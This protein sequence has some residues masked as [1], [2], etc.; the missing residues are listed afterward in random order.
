M[1]LS[2]PFIHDEKYTNLLKNETANI[3]S[4]YFPVTINP[5]LDARVQTKPIELETLCRQLGK[6]TGIKKYVLINT[7]FIHPQK[8]SDIGYLTLFLDQLEILRKTCGLSGIVFS[9]A[10]LLNA[11]S[12]T[13]HAVVSE[14]EAVPGINCMIDSVPRALAMLQLIDDSGFKRPEKLI[15][16]R[17]LNRNFKVLEQFKKQ[18][19]LIRLELLANEGCLLHCPFKPAH[20]AQIAFANLKI[21]RENTFQINQDVG[22][23]KWCHKHPHHILRS[24]FI[25]PED[26]DAYNGI[27]DTIKICGRTLGSVFLRRCITAYGRQAYDGNILDL[28]DASNWMHDIWHIENKKLDLAVLKQLSLCTKDCK[29]CTICPDLFSNTAIKKNIRFRDYKDYV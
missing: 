19:P 3:E 27:A 29:A 2:V 13:G 24:P 1:K 12:A 22:C 21:S 4:I 28:L 15:P 7:R 14:I 25:R 17:S 20:D 11:L 23:R 6:L 26:L 8:Y 10:Y 9:D 18:F 5:L 16:D